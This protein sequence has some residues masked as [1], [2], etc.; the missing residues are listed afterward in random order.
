MSAPGLY[1]RRFEGGGGVKEIYDWGAPVFFEE[2]TPW[3]E[4]LKKLR[5][6][7]EPL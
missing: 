6:L 3:V 5:D 2:I 7:L 4:H 1:V